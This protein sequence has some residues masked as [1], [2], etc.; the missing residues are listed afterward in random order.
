MNVVNPFQQNCLRLWAKKQ[1]NLHLLNREEFEKYL[2][3]AYLFDN[4]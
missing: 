2:C 3:F 1:P 4:I